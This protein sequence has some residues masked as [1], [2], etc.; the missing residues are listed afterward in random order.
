MGEMQGCTQ[1]STF[2]WSRRRRRRRSCVGWSWSCCVRG[3]RFAAW[4]TQA[5]RLSIPISA[6]EAPID[7]CACNICRPRRLI[8]LMIHRQSRQARPAPSVPAWPSAERPATPASRASPPA[9]TRGDSTGV[10][11]PNPRNARRCLALPLD[12]GHDNSKHHGAELT[13]ELLGCIQCNKHYYMYNQRSS[14]SIR[15]GSST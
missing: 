10:G 6:D 8:D 4:H 7:P 5:C 3:S 14:A 11:W 12:E 1:C 13:G 2:Y 9:Y 15:S